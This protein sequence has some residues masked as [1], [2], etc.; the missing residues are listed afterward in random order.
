MKKKYS[1]PMAQHMYVVASTF[2][3]G[4]NP[5]APGDKPGDAYDAPK[6]TLLI[7]C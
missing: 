4:S 5:L 3:C 1:K 7:K 6:R 2:L